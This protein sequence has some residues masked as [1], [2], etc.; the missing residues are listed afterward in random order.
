MI[1]T[2]QADSWEV[3]YQRAHGLLAVKL[4]SHWRG[5]ARGPHWVEL[6]AAITQ[7]DNNQKEFSG[8]GYLNAIGAP[9]DF[10][11]AGGSPLEQAKTAVDDAS[12][13]GR[14]VGLMT[15]MYTPYIYR[16]KRESD[17]AFA[18]FLDEQEALQKSWRRA[19]RPSRGD[20]ERD[21]AIMQW[22]VTAARSASA[23]TSCPV[24][25]GSSRSPSRLAASP[26]MFGSATTTPWA[27]SRGRLA[28]RASR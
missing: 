6:L 17:K 3:I 24:T 15:S 20:A 26:V 11:I 28:R 12:Y 19:L 13:K 5:D 10:M 21:Y 2:L 22:C 27:S 4:A 16:S 7:H 23:K 8:R 14:Y 9:A 18:T 25:V 1:V